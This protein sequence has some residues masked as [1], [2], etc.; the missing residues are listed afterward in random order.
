MSHLFLLFSSRFYSKLLI[1]E[2]VGGKASYT[3]KP[4]GSVN[5]RFAN[6]RPTTSLP[7]PNIHKTQTKLTVLNIW[8]PGR[9]SCSN[10]KKYYK[11][12]HSFLFLLMIV[13]DRAEGVEACRDN[14]PGNSS[15]SSSSKTLSL[16]GRFSFLNLHRPRANTAK[17]ATAAPSPA[18]V[19]VNGV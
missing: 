16:E 2:Q 9:R 5:W 13:G 4:T 10:P 18:V 19:L 6:T 12:A 11:K 7:C 3:W 1:K 15:S 14:T 17:P 8:L